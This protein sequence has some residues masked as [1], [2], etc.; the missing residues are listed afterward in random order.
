M[1][2]NP[3]VSII[4]RTK[5][6]PKLLKR[7][8][9]SIAGQT[10]RPIEVVLVNDGGCDLNIDE[11]KGIL[12]DIDLNYIRLE[13]NTGRAHAGNTGIEHAN[14]NYI[15]FLDD[16]DEL[17][18]DHLSVLTETIMRHDCKVVYSDANIVYRV[19]T[20]AVREGEKTGS[21]I[22]SS[23][24]FSYSDLLLDNYIPLM[25]LLFSKDVFEYGKGF[26][27]SFD[28]YEDWDLLIRIAERYPFHHIKKT[29]ADYIQWSGTQQVAHSPEFAV[30]A[31]IAHRQIINKHKDKFSADVIMEFIQV[32]RKVR[33]LNE[34]GAEEYIANLEDMIS[35]KEK[36][37]CSLSMTASA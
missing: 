20:I 30:K 22:F 24:D 28:I 16:D 31:R 8:I 19:G 23:K 5:D 36:E 25:C 3:L 21:K 34:N 14:G 35:Q 27:E 1:N 10:Y 13:E 37:L 17:Y 18:P 12:G 15:G 9:Q 4:V 6:R 29:T 26:D 11:L 32:A 2:H 33:L 7:A